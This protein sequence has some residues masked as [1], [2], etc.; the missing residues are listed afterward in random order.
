MKKVFFLTLCGL[1]VLLSSCQKELTGDGTSPNPVDKKTCALTRVSGLQWSSIQEDSTMY[2]QI[3]YDSTGRILHVITPKKDTSTY[4]YF[5]NHIDVNDPYTAD[6]GSGNEVVYDNKEKYFLQTNGLAAYSVMT[7]AN[8]LVLVDSTT[9]TYDT[10]GQ[11]T[12]LK[13]FNFMIGENPTIDYTYANGNLQ[14]IVFRNVSTY[15]PDSI[16]IKSSTLPMPGESFR[17]LYWDKYRSYDYYPWTGKMSKNMRAEAI[18]YYG[19]NVDQYTYNYDV[20]ADGLPAAVRTIWH[21]NGTLVDTQTSFVEFN[22][23]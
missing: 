6:D 22:C 4:A 7:L 11:L 23:K 12:E 21:Q 16:I 5:G 10:Q 20:N 19:S 13:D 1:Y 18:Y 2:T 3:V 15:Y 14:K 9:Y 8:G 17:F